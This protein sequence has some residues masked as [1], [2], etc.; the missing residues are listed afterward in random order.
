MEAWHR[1]D[2]E[3]VFSVE[4]SFT[5]LNHII[6]KGMN[7]SDIKDFRHRSQQAAKIVCHDLEYVNKA[8]VLVVL[9]D[10]PSYGTAMEMVAASRFGK[11]VILFAKN[12]I[13]TPWLI[14]SL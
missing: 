7:Y 1:R 2:K 6:S 8:D 11:K 5:A 3:I 4:E 12:P 9:A 10:K 13:P 14:H